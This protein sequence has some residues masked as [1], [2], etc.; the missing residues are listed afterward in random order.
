M[1]LLSHRRNLVVWSSPANPAEP[2]SPDGLAFVRLRRTGRLRRTARIGTL[3]SVI[4]LLR[5]ARA[6]RPRWRPV[7]G[8]VVLT[9]AG[10]ILHGHPWAAIVVPG[11]LLLAYSVLVPAAPDEDQKR[12][13]REL[14][15][16]STPAQRCDL[17]A[18]LGRYPD[19][20]TGGLRDI[21]FRQASAA[22]DHKIP[23]DGGRHLAEATRH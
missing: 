12:L 20:L 17:E 19:T 18:T 2:V 1:R 4:A 22:G 21:L 16:Y 3:L 15:A 13:E 8:G 9:V 7:L 23:G 5:L 6:V 11:L 10:A 14:A